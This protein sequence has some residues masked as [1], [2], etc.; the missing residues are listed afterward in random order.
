MNY[1]ECKSEMMEIKLV[2]Q[3]ATRLSST[4]YNLTK[5]YGFYPVDNGKLLEGKSTIQSVFYN[6]ATV[7][8]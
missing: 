8:E 2:R 5:K 3:A 1:K 7:S 4:W 6:D